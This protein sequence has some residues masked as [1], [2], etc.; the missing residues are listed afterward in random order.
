V[1]PL[2]SALTLLSSLAAASAATYQVGNNVSNFT[3]VA[4]HPFTNHNGQVFTSNAP[5][6]LR[7]FAGRIIFLEFFAV[8]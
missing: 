3:L 1:K 7:D 6:Q 5:V 4:R 8:W 2:L